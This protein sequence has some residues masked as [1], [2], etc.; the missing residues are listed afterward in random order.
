MS[1][2]LELSKHAQKRKTSRVIGMS[3]AELIKGLEVAQ[4]KGMRTAAI[5][6]VTDTAIANIKTGRVIT[7]M[8]TTRDGFITNIDGVVFV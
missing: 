2:R 7:M 4:A 8:R 5:I 3:Q 6:S 1:G